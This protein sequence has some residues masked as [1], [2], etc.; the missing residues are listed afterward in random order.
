MKRPNL[1]LYLLLLSFWACSLDKHVETIFLQADSLLAERPD[2]A[3]YLLETLADTCNLSASESAYYA[4]LLARATDKCEKSLLP[5]DSL[6]DLALD[7]YDSDQK[8]RAITLLYKG[9]LEIEMEQSERAIGFLLEGLDIIRNYPEEIE[10]KRHLLSSLGNE[11]YNVRLYEK[12][13]NTFDELYRCCYTD[14]DKAIALYNLGHY[15]SIIGENDSAIFCQRKALEYGVMQKDSAMVDLFT[16]KLSAVYSAQE[17]YDSALY[18]AKQ[19]LLWH[20]QKEKPSVHYNNIGHIF[21]LKDNLDSA[22][23]YMNKSLE[24]SSRLSLKEK[25]SILLNLGCIKEEQENYLECTDLLFQFIEIVDSVYR[26]NQSTKIE[27]LVH[28]YDIKEKL[29]RAQQKNE[30]VL[31]NI[32]AAFIFGGLILVLF[33]Q[34][35]INKQN[36]LKIVIE[37]NLR[38]ARERYKNLEHSIAESQHIISLLQKKQVDFSQENERYK[39]EIKEREAI[40]EKLTF[41]KEN[42]RIWLFKQSAIYKKILRLSTQE[43]NCKKELLVLGNSDQKKLKEVVWELFADFISD[44]KIHYSLLTEEDLLYLC[45]EKAELSNQTIALCFGNTDTHIIAQRK[46]RIKERMNRDYR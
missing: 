34:Y 4:L 8:E 12:A 16:G 27:Q 15:Y 39:L 31:K 19:S 32:V 30:S 9:R 10:T 45:L 25:A 22:A 40:I 29:S 36:K 21:Y 13:K 28:Q 1:I 20:S 7:Y 18:Y 38:Q 23:Y 37:Q 24:D 3:L 46:Y 14:K 5:C 6:L 43:V 33:F 41:E 11:Y 17:Q 44:M 2:S 35:R 26:T 42:L